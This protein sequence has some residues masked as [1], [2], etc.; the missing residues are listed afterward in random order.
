MGAHFCLS[1]PRQPIRFPLRSSHT[2][3]RPLC[4]HMRTA[5]SSMKQTPASQRELARHINGRRLN[6]LKHV[7]VPPEH[8]STH[9]DSTRRQ[10]HK[11]WLRYFARYAWQRTIMSFHTS[12]QKRPLNTYTKWQSFCPTKCIL[13]L[14]GLLWVGL[15]FSRMIL[16]KQSQ[17]PLLLLYRSPTDIF[18]MLD[19]H[20]SERG[21]QVVFVV[22]CTNV[23]FLLFNIYQ[24]QAKIYIEISGAKSTQ[25]SCTRRRRLSLAQHPIRR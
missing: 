11:R 13:S 1:V 18:Q 9:P 24:A 21:Y 8:I 2:T 19:L 4:T 17:T 23:V 12:A 5:S 25:A 3:Q 14:W 15:L 22:K 7:S 20:L 10:Q 16:I 6:P